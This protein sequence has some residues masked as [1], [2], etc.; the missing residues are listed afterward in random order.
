MG[1][2]I[3]GFTTLSFPHPPNA[4][5]TPAALHSRSPGWISA[6]VAVAR[7]CP[8]SVTAQ[9]VTYVA[10]TTRAM[11]SCSSKPLQPVKIIVDSGLIPLTFHLAYNGAPPLAAAQGE[12]AAAGGTPKAQPGCSVSTQHAESFPFVINLAATV[13]GHLRI[14]TASGDPS[15]EQYIA[16]CGAAFEGELHNVRSTL[17]SLMEKL[18]RHVRL[19]RPGTPMQSKL[20]GALARRW[21]MPGAS[22]IDLVSAVSLADTLVQPG[23]L[24]SSGR[25]G[26]PRSALLTGL[27]LAAAHEFMNDAAQVWEGWWG[28]GVAGGREAGGCNVATLGLLGQVGGPGVHGV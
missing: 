13:S 16:R 25:N 23:L 7:R 11:V 12:G 20:T 10:E 21:S 24:P 1:C 19:S 8:P 18:L 6:A 9:V 5:A 26:G 2:G 14:A 15:A 22:R 28:G 4:P 27:L 17:V 3:S